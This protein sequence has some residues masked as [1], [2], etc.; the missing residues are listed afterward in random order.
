[1]VVIGGGNSGI[2]AAM[3]LSNVASEVTLV[4]YTESLTGDATLRDRIEYLGNVTIITNAEAKRIVGDGERV[5]SLEYIN[6]VTQESVQLD[7]DGVFIQIGL[8]PNS[9]L[10]KGL[11]KL[12]PQNEI[13]IDGS[14]RTKSKGIYAAGD[15]TTVPYKQIVVAQ[16]EGAKAAI[17][18]FED[19][20]SG[21]I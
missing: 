17:A 8:L 19:I 7:V 1:M 13:V 18:A 2:E 14:C 6:R 9:A 16:G 5:T 21:V 10:F 15:V 11:V 20:V 3:D 12:S 4:E